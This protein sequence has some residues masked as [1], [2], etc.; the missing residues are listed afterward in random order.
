MSWIHHKPV[1][2]GLTVSFGPNC[3]LRTVMQIEF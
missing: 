1:G 3:G 2:D